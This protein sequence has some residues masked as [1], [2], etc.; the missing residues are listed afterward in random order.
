VDWFRGLLTAGVTFGTIVSIAV[1]A[2]YTYILV[3]LARHEE[4]FD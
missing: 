1:G 2:A 4:A 3:A